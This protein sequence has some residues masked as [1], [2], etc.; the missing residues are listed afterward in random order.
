MPTSPADTLPDRAPVDNELVRVRGQLWVVS[1]VVPGPENRPEPNT[2]VHLQSVE[3]GRYDQRLSVIW[4][5]EPG[6]RILPPANLPRVAA[7]RFDPPHRLAAFLDAMRWSSGTSAEVRTLQAPFRSGVAVEPYQLVPVVSATRTPRVNQLL[8]DDVGLGKTIEAGLVASEL[9]LRHRARKVM[10][11]CP[12]GLTVKW[13]DEMFEKFGLDFHIVNSES[14]A[15][16][17]RTHGS[18][19]NPF[20]IHPLMIVS[21]PWLRGPKAQR[22]LDELLPTKVDPSDRTFDLLILDE[23]HHIA[24]AA[25]KQRYAVDSLQTK[26]IRKLA[27]HFE[28]RL[29]LSATPHNGYP[30]SFQALLEIIDPLRF[31]RGVAPDG[32]A[33]DDTMIRRMKNDIPD[34][35]GKPRF[36][37]RETFELPVA[38]SEAEHELHRDLER[39]AVE[40][41][42]RLPTRRGKRAADL[43]TLL[44]KKRLISSPEAFARTVGVYLEASE[45]PVSES[46]YTD[47]ELDWGWNYEDDTADLDDGEATLFEDDT[48]VGAYRRQVKVTPEERAILE[49]M[50]N[51]AQAFEHRP[52]AKAKALIE[53]LR[54]ICKADGE[55]SDERVVVFTEYRDT[56]TWLEG[57]LSQHGLGNHKGVR[58]LGLL[59]GGMDVNDRELLRLAFQAEPG[60][61]PVRILLATDAAG[62]GI[63]LQDHC[64]RLINYDIPFNPNKLEQ[65]IG[66]I[67]RYGQR[68][69]P[70]IH[71]FVPEGWRDKGDPMY[72]ELEFLSRVARK[73]VA[74]EADLGAINAVLAKGIQERMTRPDA[75]LDIDELTAKAGK[76]T[77]VLSSNRQIAD[78]VRTSVET[79]AATRETM[80]LTPEAMHRVVS[81]ALELAKQ[82]PLL[83][84]KTRGWYEV[85]NLGNVWVRAKQGLE[86]KL[87]KEGKEP[88]E[89]PI[90]FDPELARGR[91][92]VVLTHLGHPLLEMSTALLKSAVNSETSSMNRVTALVTDDPAVDEVVVASY[93]RFVLVGRDGLRLH[94]EVLHVGGIM[95][96]SG[97]FRRE[98]VTRLQE[99]LGHAVSRGKATSP[100][101][102]RRL[103]EAWP[104]AEDGIRLALNAR[105]AEKHGQIAN[106]LDRRRRD[107]EDRVTGD[108]ERFKATLAAAVE[109]TRPDENMLP[110]PDVEA[111]RRQWEADRADISRRLERLDDDLAAELA[112]IEERYRDPEAH[113]FPIAT[114]FVVPLKE[115]TR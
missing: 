77:A 104:K 37:S 64:H 2:L 54:T 67:D 63:D 89:R 46:S 57:L 56:Q 25:P 102:H 114:V 100:V 59:H 4:E 31:A 12:A 115:A 7:D 23:A 95:P 105:G 61:D 6:R 97:Q 79:M 36:K 55:W 96:E 69:N 103:A 42:K 5:V 28:H 72:A 24:P 110:T 34:A 52:D 32:K 11:V 71:H 39:F 93:A 88:V 48:L 91:D 107:E 68:H 27:P 78:R 41:K 90:T 51:A 38:Y 49:R 21:L 99:I 76:K 98:G 101:V 75:R 73:V 16:L 109:D 87:P 65:R 60:R 47:E 108:I 86:E 66:R 10:V 53:H 15:V 50:Q 83:E 112:S 40:R 3:D 18:A 13:R 94:E 82:P 8:A 113:L 111:E 58:R 85:P 92:D 17:R 20:A 26:L 45:K 44:F 80:N 29:F 35:D 22:L 1:G 33:L 81:T 19:A 62:E 14:A 43:V 70:L 30:E 9:L 84:T 106:A 74:M